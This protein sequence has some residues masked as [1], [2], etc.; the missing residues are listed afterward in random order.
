MSGTDVQRPF[1]LSG[2]GARGFAHLGV[3]QA[4]G[5]EGITPSAI[6]GTSAGALIGAFIASGMGPEEVRDRLAKDLKFSL[7]SW[8]SFRNGF[9]GLEAVADYLSE[10][11]GV[12]RFED[13]TIPLYVTATDLE[14]G[15]QQVFSEGPLI[16]PLLASSSIPVI[17]PPREIDGHRYIDGGLSNNLPVE[18]FADRLQEVVAVYVNPLPPL[19]DDTSMMSV[20]DRS[21]HLGFRTTV[22]RS[23][24]GC[25]VLIE[26]PGLA[27]Y[28]IFDLRKVKEIY[29]IGYEHARK[30]LADG[31]LT[32]VAGAGVQ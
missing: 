2:G 27:D 28:G 18:P 8:N 1:V 32:A 19:D 21:W 6:S 22:M 30:L 4:L 14:D 24:K 17:F 31:E 25:G 16:D 7:F 26:P 20:L 13:L 10:T 29:A 23:A 5:E 11:L 12:E 3:L 15:R 9:L